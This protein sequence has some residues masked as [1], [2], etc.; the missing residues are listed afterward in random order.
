MSR[1]GNWYDNA[2]AEIFFS[3]LE[4]EHICQQKIAMFRQARKM[5]DE[6]IHCYN[7]KRIRLKTEVA[8]LVAPLHVK[9]V[10]PSSG[11]K[12]CCRFSQRMR[13]ASRKKQQKDKTKKGAYRSKYSFCKRFFH[14]WDSPGNFV[15]LHKQICHSDE[16]R[17]NQCSCTFLRGIFARSR[18]N[19]LA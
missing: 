10:F 17:R 4:A 15:S 1:R 5:T 12:L 7:D 18:Y 19:F 11:L 9:Y 2:M 14:R 13:K 16:F 6:V 8:C 3:I